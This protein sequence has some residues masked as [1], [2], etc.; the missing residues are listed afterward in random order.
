MLRW[1]G[2]EPVHKNSN[3]EFKSQ[4]DPVSQE[5]REEI[6]RL[7]KEDVELYNDA[8]YLRK[9]RRAKRFLRRFFF[10]ICFASRG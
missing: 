2:V 7:N 10:H 4:F 9:I 3:R 1:D 5:D 8:L 6:R